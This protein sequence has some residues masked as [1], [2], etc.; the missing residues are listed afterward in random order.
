MINCSH[1][2]GSKME[3]ALIDANK[4]KLHP[5]KST[6]MNFILSPNSFI[7]DS[8]N[9]NIES[10]ENTFNS[11]NWQ[12]VLNF[13]FDLKSVFILISVNVVFFHMDKLLFNIFLVVIFFIR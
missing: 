1:I 9:Q 13:L 2:Y 4:P 10:A 6:S 3:D 11:T 5:V 7:T 8:N 12:I